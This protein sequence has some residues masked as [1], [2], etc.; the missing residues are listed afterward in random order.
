M[1]LVYDATD[2]KLLRAI[3]IERKTGNFDFALSPD[4]R[5]VAIFDGARIRLY[6]ID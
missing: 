5:Q 4:G 6:V 2:P 1:L 3:P